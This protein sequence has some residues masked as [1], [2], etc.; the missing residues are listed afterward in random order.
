MSDTFELLVIGGG[1]AAD[2]VVRA[3]RYGRRE[4]AEQAAAVR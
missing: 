4:I 1:P 2:A 3:Y